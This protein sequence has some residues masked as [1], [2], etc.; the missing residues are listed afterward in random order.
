MWGW[1][2]TSG[3]DMENHGI[4]PDIVVDNDPDQVAQGKDPQLEAGVRLLVDQLRATR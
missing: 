2:T 3:E 1:F 4:Q